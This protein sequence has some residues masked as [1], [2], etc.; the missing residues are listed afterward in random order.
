MEIVVGVDDLLFAPSRAKEKG[1]GAM[2]RHL[3]SRYLPSTRLGLQMIEDREWI[4]DDAVF[5][6]AKPHAVVNVV[7][8]HLEIQFVEASVHLFEQCFSGGETSAG[9]RRSA[10]QQVTAAEVT[11]VSRRLANAFVTG[12]TLDS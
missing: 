1:F 11:A 8:C 12:D 7:E 2:P 5:G 6:L 9:D 10:S 4:V 3:S